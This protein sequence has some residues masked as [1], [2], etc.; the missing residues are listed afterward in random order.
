MA[1]RK[2][3]DQSST[4]QHLSMLF[5]QKYVDEQLHCGHTILTDDV[6]INQLYSNVAIS[7]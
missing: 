2:K 1:D 5:L 3:L 4:D 6:F 7:G